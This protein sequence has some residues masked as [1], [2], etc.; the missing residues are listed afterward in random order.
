MEMMGKPRIEDLRKAVIIEILSNYHKYDEEE[1]ELKPVYKVPQKEII[2]RLN[3]YNNQGEPDNEDKITPVMVSKTLTSMEEEGIITRE[4]LPDPEGKKPPQKVNYLKYDYET[5]FLI[6]KAFYIEDFGEFLTNSFNLNFVRSSY[7]KSII[8]MDL[9]KYFDDR[10]YLN[11]T[12]E[13]EDIL[14]NIIKTSPLALRY[15][16]Y[17]SEDMEQ[18]DYDDETV[19]EKLKEMMKDD[20]TIEGYQ[21]QLKEE[22]INNIELSGADPGF[23][24]VFKH[25]MDNYD[26]QDYILNLV[27]EDLFKAKTKGEFNQKFFLKVVESMEPFKEIMEQFPDPSPFKQSFF[28]F[29]KE[30]GS[31]EA[32]N[33]LKKDK[34]NL[35]YRIISSFTSDL[36]FIWNFV[37]PLDIDLEIN[38]KF[39]TPENNNPHHIPLL[40]IETGE[41][42][43]KGGL[44]IQGIDDSKHHF[45]LPLKDRLA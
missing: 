25:V 32:L 23:I 27:D 44:S 7:A 42:E 22:L 31:Q 5:L 41:N 35:F 45:L 2:R 9:V 4:Q 3:W 8:N 15:I 24:K 33:K 16:F 36:N 34:E 37:P 39:S 10:L 11:L 19:K 38:I 13:E 18:I 6:L 28:S 20:L 29:A 30:L 14:L 1:K 43:I 21:V 17:E 40:S 26:Y 12:K